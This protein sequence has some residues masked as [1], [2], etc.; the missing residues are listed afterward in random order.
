MTTPEI[1]REKLDKLATL[2]TPDAIA[3]ELEAQGIKA[4]MGSAHTCAVA[5]YLGNPAKIDPEKIG[6]S[7]LVGVTRDRVA[8]Y[9][10]NT[11]RYPDIEVPEVVRAFIDAFDQRRYPELINPPPKD[12]EAA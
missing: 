9:V 5:R 1:V 4:N 12:L 7:S 2:G 10:S 6:S 8:V 11:N 3:L